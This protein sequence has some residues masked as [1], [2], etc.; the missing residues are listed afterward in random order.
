[1]LNHE[2]L[3]QGIPIPQSFPASTLVCAPNKSTVENLQ[4]TSRCYSSRT[5]LL[6]EAN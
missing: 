4:M 1:M 5:N 6:N 3:N 2:F